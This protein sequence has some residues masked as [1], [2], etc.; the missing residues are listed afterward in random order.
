MHGSQNFAPINHFL[1]HFFHELFEVAWCYDSGPSWE[2]QIFFQSVD[3]TGASVGDAVLWWRALPF[4]IA[5]EGLLVT[6]FTQRLSRLM[7]DGWLPQRSGTC[8]WPAP[9]LG[10]LL[11]LLRFAKLSSA[12]GLFGSR[13]LGW[14]LH[15]PLSHVSA[16]LRFG[17]TDDALV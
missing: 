4:R 12:V 13:R 2:L 17:S 6:L 10:C 11:Y 8:V 14:A 9:H 1:F 7:N 16:N 15:I 5:P 3:H